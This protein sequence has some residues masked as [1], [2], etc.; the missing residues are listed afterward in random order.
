MT[1]MS[2]AVSDDVSDSHCTPDDG[3]GKEGRKEGRGKNGNPTIYVMRKIAA[4]V[5]CREGR[6]GT[7]GRGRDLKIISLLEIFSREAR[8]PAHLLSLL[9]SVRLS[10]MQY[11]SMVV[12]TNRTNA[13]AL[14][15]RRRLCL[16]EN[17]RCGSCV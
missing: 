17:F 1:L 16:L 6:A 3:D 9:L 5:L 7:A 11:A 4:S 15:P 10:E 2:C 12:I 14:G 8:V 13:N